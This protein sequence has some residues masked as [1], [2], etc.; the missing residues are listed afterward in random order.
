MVP[1]WGAAQPLGLYDEIYQPYKPLPGGRLSTIL[2]ITFDDYEDRSNSIV[3]KDR[4]LIA[5]QGIPVNAKITKGEVL[6]RD[7]QS[8]PV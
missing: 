1:L 8:R 3:L 7:S 6:L 5:A 4:V 2:G